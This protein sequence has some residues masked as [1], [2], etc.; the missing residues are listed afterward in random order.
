MTSNL[1]PLADRPPGYEAGQPRHIVKQKFRAS[2]CQMRS[3]IKRGEMTGAD[4]P[5]HHHPRGAPSDDSRDAVLDNQA[6]F[7][8]DAHRA[9]RVQKKIRTWFSIRDVGGGK[10]VGREHG[11]VAG[12]AKR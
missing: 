1:R 4:K 2:R 7:R 10:N 8:L 6:V 3:I 9:R 5:E 11:L 12:H